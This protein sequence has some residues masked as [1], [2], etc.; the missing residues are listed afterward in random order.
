MCFSLLD[1][2]CR[3]YLRLNAI[4]GYKSSYIFRR[5]EIYV[6]NIEGGE[7]MSEVVEQIG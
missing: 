3:D 4:K 7:M 2:K 6:C 1:S 5:H